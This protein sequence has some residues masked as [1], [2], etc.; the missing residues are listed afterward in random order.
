M[1]TKKR[2]LRQKMEERT[3]ERA[4]P[5]TGD[6]DNDGAVK[7]GG[8]EEKGRKAM[9][10]RSVTPKSAAEGDATV[11]QLVESINASLVAAEPRRALLKQD[12]YKVRINDDNYT[13]MGTLTLPS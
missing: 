11:Q 1:R 9:F 3:L 4:S 7:S 12:A 6:D 5:A 8:R 2:Y 10:V 13:S